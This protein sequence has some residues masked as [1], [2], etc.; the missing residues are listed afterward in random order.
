MEGR[1]TD[2]VA[3]VTGGASGIG[4]AVCRRLVAEGAKVVVA[5]I[6][7]AR[8][9]TVANTLGPAA[10][11]HSFDA[12]DVASV[13]R[14]VTET[15]ER[16]GRLDILHNNAAIVSP[17]VHAGDTTVV[18]IDFKILDLVLNVNLRG[19]VAGCKYAIPHM[20]AGGGGRIVNT[21]SC[22]GMNGD[23]T[24]TAYGLSKAAIINLTRQVAAQYGPQGIGC[25]AV[26]P[27]LVLT[28]AAREVAKD[29]ISIMERHLLT[30]QIGEPEDLAALV[31]F[32]A[33][34]EARYI[35]GQTYVMDGGAT[36][37]NPNYADLKELAAKTKA[38]AKASAEV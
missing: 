15:V 27:G 24:R 23:F 26:A 14:L 2:Q 8:A 25:N 30:P 34:S 38:K 1:F 13:E 22:S 6:D 31:C 29:V 35:N 7:A 18:D 9:T 17:E 32:L 12:G 33:S 10:T 21:T 19:Y 20:L 5:D 4:E 28:P 16:H 36:S 3:I 11:A 37:H